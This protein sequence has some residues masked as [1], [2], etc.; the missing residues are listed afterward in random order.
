VPASLAARWSIAAIFNEALIYEFTH[1]LAAYITAGLVAGVFAVPSYGTLL[2]AVWDRRCPSQ[3][4]PGRGPSDSAGRDRAPTAPPDSTNYRY[5]GK[6][7]RYHRLGLAILFTAVAI[8]APLQMM[9]GDTVARDMFQ[10]MRVKFAAIETVWTTGPDK[11]ET[12]WT[13]EPGPGR[14][15][16][17][18]ADPG[19]ASWL[20]GFSTS[21]V[22]TGLSGVLSSAGSARLGNKRRLVG[23]KHGREHFNL[24]SLAGARHAPTRG[25]TPANA[26]ATGTVIT[27]TSD[28]GPFWLD[29][30]GAHPAPV[31]AD[32]LA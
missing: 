7:D 8:V 10:E 20:P 4:E 16:G 32:D 13:I 11:P 26:S 14:D 25:R 22:I 15:L 17:R 21:T 9:I 6:W 29:C 5:A 24:L 27:R 19:P 23:R 12:S 28:T 30:H 31:G 1:M 18:P 2:N 3:N